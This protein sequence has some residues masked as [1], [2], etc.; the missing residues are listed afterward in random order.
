MKEVHSN[1]ALLVYVEKRRQSKLS[2]KLKH[3]CQ[4]VLLRT[5]VRWRMFYIEIT[6]TY[7]A[8]YK[9]P[10]SQSSVVKDSSLATDGSRVDSPIETCSLTSSQKDPWWRVDLEKEVLV[11]DVYI[12]V[13]YASVDYLLEIRVGNHDE[14]NLKDNSLCGSSLDSNRKLG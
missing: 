10:T 6:M 7:N 11:R 4:G 9:K 13:Y 5:P 1:A 14:P 2:L 12:F 3:V 8:A